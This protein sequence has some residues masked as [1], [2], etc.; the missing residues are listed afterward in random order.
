MSST[1]LAG[2]HALVTGAGSGI[3]HAVALRLA[4]AGARVSVAGRQRAP[5]E[6]LRAELGAQAGACC[7]M[8]VTDADAVTKGCEALVAEAGA[9]QIIV[10]SAGQAASAP[11]ARTDA[12]LFQSLFAVNVLGVHQVTQ[13]LLP[14]MRA[15]GAGRIVAIASTAG[16]TGYRYVSAYATSKHAVIGLVRSLAVELARTGITVNAVCPGFTDTPLLDEAVANIVQTTGRTAEEARVELARGNPTGRL[17][18]PHEV[19][20]A[21]AWLCGPDASAVTGQAIV[22]AGGEVLA[23]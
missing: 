10:H 21:V 9:V 16:L 19:A 1:I 18:A 4:A 6:A 12:T 20:D 8:D 17:V 13:A 3:G 14:A 11:Y 7:T 2:A 5:L 15:A 22:V 23:G